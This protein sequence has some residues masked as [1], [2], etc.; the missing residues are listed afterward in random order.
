VHGIT[1]WV[2]VAGYGM[3]IQGTAK[4]LM[5]QGEPENTVACSITLYMAGAGVGI[6]I[7]DPACLCAIEPFG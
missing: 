7:E 3:V 4:G 6:I 1:V 5:E 2:W